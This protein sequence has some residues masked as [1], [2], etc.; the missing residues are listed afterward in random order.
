M[1]KNLHYWIMMLL[2]IILLSSCG[3]LKAKQVNILDYVELEFDGLDTNGNVS[4][5]VDHDAVLMDIIGAKNPEEYEKRLEKLY[6]KDNE[7]Y[8]TLMELDSKYN[9]TIDKNKELSN[10]DK[11]TLTVEVEEDAKDFLEN[12]KKEFTVD[13]LESPEIIA[14]TDVEKHIVTYF[15]GANGRGYIQTENTFNNELNELDFT[16]DNDGKLSNGDK[17]ELKL[18]EE[19]GA[20]RAIDLGYKLEDDFK[21]EIEVE[22]LV[23][24]PEKAEDIKNLKDI[25]RMIKELA[26]EIFQDG[27]GKTYE[28]KQEVLLYR[29]FD[30][31]IEPEQNLLDDKV[32]IDLKTNGSLIALYSV[33]EYDEYSKEEEK[34]IAKVGYENLA[35][36]KNGKVNV[37]EMISVGGEYS[38]RETRSL[39]TVQQIYEGNGYEV[40]K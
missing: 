7:T 35:L 19:D 18:I 9:I 23:E 12:G 25:K 11:I 5:V 13:G 29:Q 22:G 28:I 17:V 4:F 20:T 39:E 37:A 1:K 34:F 27:F 24:F 3:G 36:E 30:D 32:S 15:I 31:E 2:S 38:N 21:V 14:S 6:N 16:V 40:V 10:G 8:F 26:E 33:K